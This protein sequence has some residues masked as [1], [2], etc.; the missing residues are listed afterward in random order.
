MQETARS[1]QGNGFIVFRNALSNAEVESGM[2]CINVQDATVNYACIEHFIRMSM[3]SKVGTLL[4]LSTPIDFI[5]YRVSDNNNSADAAGFHRDLIWKSSGGAWQDIFMP[6]FT[7]LTYFDTTVLELI[8][9]SHL[10]NYSLHET[11]D[12]YRQLLRVEMRP[13]DILLFYSSLLHRGVFTEGILHRRLIQVFE[14]FLNPRLMHAFS[15][16]ILHVPGDETFSDWMVKATK[17]PGVLVNIINAYGYLNAATGYGSPQHIDRCTR[18]IKCMFLSSEGLRGRL[19]VQPDTWQPINKYILNPVVPAFDLPK[20]CMGVYRY[21]VFHR[22][23]YAY[24]IIIAFY[25]IVVIILVKWIVS[26]YHQN[27][28]HDRSW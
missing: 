20:S 19:I 8:P 18:G 27:L 7:C 10:R 3:M 21:Y 22:Q 9:G 5:K 28:A 11:A 26:W 24:S 17:K 12:V 13:G 1:L 16:L 2:R 4:G 25:V 14:V 23:Y 15:P 6:C